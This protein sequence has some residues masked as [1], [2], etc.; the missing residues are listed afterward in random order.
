VSTVLGGVAAVSLMSAPAHAGIFDSAPRLTALTTASRFAANALCTVLS[1]LHVSTLHPT[2]AGHQ[3]LQPAAAPKL[4]GRATHSRTMLTACA[5]MRAD[6][7][8]NPA[9]DAKKEIFKGEEKVKQAVPKLPSKSD[10][11]KPL[12]QLEKR[13]EQA[14]AP[15]R[16]ARALAAHA[17]SALAMQCTCLCSLALECLACTALCAHCSAHLVCTWS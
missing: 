10:A 7:P 12:A 8:S 2:S 11:P 16:Q 6:L 14:T 4:S 3:Q 13:V 1:P 5:C 9:Q 17:S 15:S